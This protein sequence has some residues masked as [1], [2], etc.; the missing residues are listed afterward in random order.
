MS[1]TSFR[2]QQAQT[3]PITTPAP[4]KGLNTIDPLEQMEAA[5]G[6]S[7]QNWIATPQGLSQRTG[8]RRWAWGLPAAAT[9]LLPYNGRSSTSN[10]H[11]AVCGDV[12]KDITLGGD[13]S[14]G[15]FTVVSGL[16]AS[17]PY[18]QYTQMTYSTGSTNYLAMVNGSDAPLLFNGTT[19]TTCAQV[20]S[21][22]SPGQ[23]KT[24]D[25]AGNTVNIATFVDVLTH[26][27]R[28]WFVA[29][30]STKAYYCDIAQVGGE[31]Y[32]FDFGPWFAR[33]GKL[34]KLATW[35][36]DNGSG[37]TARL[38]AISSKGDVVIYD[39][40][41]PATSAT[42]VQSGTY[43]LGA[44]VNR[45][46]IVPY[47]GDLLMLTQDGLYAISKY[48]QSARLDATQA[49]TYRISNVIA[50]L[51][52]TLSTLPGF[53]LGINPANDT[54]LLNIPQPDNQSNFQFCF[55]AL[56]QGWTQ[57]TG[58]PAITYSNFNDGFYFGSEEYV[59]LAFIG[60]AD[61]ADING[62][63]GNN[64]L[65][66]GLTAFNAMTSDVTGPGMLKHAK[67]VK[68]YIVTGQVNPTIRVGVNT[69]FNL[70]PITGSATVN[71][72]TGAVWDN[73]IWDNPGSTWVGS[74]TT[75]NQW[76]TPLCW[77]GTY[78]AFAISLS[79]TSDTI[80]SA[81]NWIVAPS[82]SQFG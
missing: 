51:V 5:Y 35:S 9:T 43:Q 13:V 38:V 30:N 7:L 34:F 19:W 21:P 41:N 50:D 14:S 77:P 24:T 65:A 39:G 11:F 4:W 15:A 63:G 37:T 52:S 48:M 8:F 25:H 6:L 23:F 58:W 45:R 16:N 44:P 12:I 3:I 27:Q 42:W 2:P 22:A 46:C 61:D 54:V 10:R 56:T 76:A 20:G 79:A 32:P 74:L 40:N 72:V 68:P 29:E 31:L 81:T 80:W 47:Q 57:F 70:I 78:L 67:L 17:A 49:L 36:I 62:A 26:Q 33:G 18:W 82:T 71:P 60:Y 53:E 28:L 66:T 1:R 75:Y 59:A 64:I 55:N 69:D 73:A